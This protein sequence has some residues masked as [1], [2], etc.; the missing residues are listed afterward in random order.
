MCAL[1]VAL[2]LA[3]SGCTAGTVQ[4]TSAPSSPLPSSGALPSPHSATSPPKAG[5]PITDL[6]KV[7]GTW[8]TKA[9]TG[10]PGNPYLVISA[11][12]TA[13]GS[14]GCNS[15]GG[16]SWVTEIS[17]ITFSG[18]VRTLVACPHIPHTDQWLSRLT[19][20]TINDDVMTCFDDAGSV[21][22]TLPRTE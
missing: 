2:A 19:T 15:F 3:L 20:A 18:G 10:G 12:G 13:S 9:E 17:T 8:G 4:W 16:L 1:A 7:V 14:D 6:S 11:D 5:E 22:G 21:I